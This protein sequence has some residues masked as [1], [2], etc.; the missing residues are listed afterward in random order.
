MRN[1]LFL[2]KNMTFEASKEINWLSC[3][4]FWWRFVVWSPLQRGRLV[5]L[6][7]CGKTDNKSLSPSLLWD[8]SLNKSPVCKKCALKF[9]GKLHILLAVNRKN[10]R[11]ARGREIKKKIKEAAILAVAFQE[12]RAAV[13]TPWCLTIVHNRLNWV[14]PRFISMERSHNFSWKFLYWM[15]RGWSFL[16]KYQTSL[17]TAEL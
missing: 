2:R 6:L 16:R 3:P 5:I 17:P 8:A 14:K 7:F 11:E 1:R 4:C 15:F 12:R 10:Q 9:V 13:I